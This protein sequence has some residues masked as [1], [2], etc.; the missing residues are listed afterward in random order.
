MILTVFG[1]TI[2]QVFKTTFRVVHMVYSSRYI[3]AP[4][5]RG[6]TLQWIKNC[7]IKIY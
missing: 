6:F 2:V 3:L 5:P 7:Q 1:V 4:E